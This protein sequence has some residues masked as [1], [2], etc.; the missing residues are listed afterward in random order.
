[1]TSLSSPIP[2]EEFINI[3][4]STPVMTVI[5]PLFC[6]GDQVIAV[7]LYNGFQL[8]MFIAHAMSVGVD[9]LELVCALS[10]QYQSSLHFLL[11]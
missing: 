7:L 3:H 1:M 5:P 4:H 8:L 6:D 9:V 11:Y 10:L 2:S